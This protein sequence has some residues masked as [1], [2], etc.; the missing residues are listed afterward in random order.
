MHGCQRSERPEEGIGAAGGA[1]AG[2][3][4]TL[5]A[6]QEPDWGFLKEQQLLSTAEPSFQSHVHNILYQKH[7]TMVVFQVA[8]VK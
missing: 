1:V 6:F 5:D 2:N 4:E 8:L 3:C 7:V